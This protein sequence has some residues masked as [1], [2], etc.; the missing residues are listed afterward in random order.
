M[1]KNISKEKREN[2][3]AKIK[4][5]YSYIAKAEQDENTGNL[6]AYLREL[7][8]EA[9]GKKCGQIN[10]LLE[11]DNLAALKLLLKTHKG[12]IDIIYIDPPYNTG[13]K[14]WK[15]DNDYRVLAVDKRKHIGG[16]SPKA[17]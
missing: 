9:K 7:E 4:A 5:I 13:A 2:L 3:I 14:D 11:G 16:A 8:K 6:L 17:H 10:F 15:Y 1:S 12:K